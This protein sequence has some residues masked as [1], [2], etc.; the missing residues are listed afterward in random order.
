[1]FEEIPEA[2]Q[3]DRRADQPEGKCQ[4]GKD[5]QIDQ[6]KNNLESFKNLRENLKINGLDP[7]TFPLVV[8]FNK[9]DL[10][11]IVDFEEIRSVYDKK[12][13]PVFPASAMKMEGVLETLGGLI[14]I[15]FK[16][17]NSKY[18]LEDKFGIRSQ[19]FFDKIMTSLHK[20]SEAST[21]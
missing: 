6:W 20:P 7:E 16:S 3:K 8:Q 2:P 15:T 21:P 10:P 1:M 12:G 13:I 5:S 4:P 9:R 18:Q 17:L 19:D 11:N 14:D